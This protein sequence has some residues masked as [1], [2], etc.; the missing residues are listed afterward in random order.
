VCAAAVQHEVTPPTVGDLSSGPPPMEG[1]QDELEDN[2]E[3]HPMIEESAADTADIWDDQEDTPDSEPMLVYRSSVIWIPPKGG[4]MMKCVH[5]MRFIEQVLPPNRRK[6]G[7][8][9]ISAVS[10]D[11]LVEPVYH[12]RS[13]QKSTA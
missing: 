8:L 7:Q 3:D 6:A 9:N 4:I 11:K 5:A 10:V 12:H 2:L 13:R 1:E